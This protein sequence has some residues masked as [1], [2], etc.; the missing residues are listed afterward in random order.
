MTK[1]EKAIGAYSE[2]TGVYL[3]ALRDY[4]DAMEAFY[5]TTVQELV[6]LSQ[7]EPVDL[8]ECARAA[9]RRDEIAKREQEAVHRLNE[10]KI[11]AI[12]VILAEKETA[13]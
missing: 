11:E 1:A 9:L 2:A 7:G 3:S 4:A 8:Y 5:H 12:R 13:P 6:G 10:A